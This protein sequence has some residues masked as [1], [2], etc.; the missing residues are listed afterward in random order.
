MLPEL[1]RVTPTFTVCVTLLER[2]VTHCFFAG[3][4][5]SVAPPTLRSLSSAFMTL[6]AGALFFAVMGRQG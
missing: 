5:F 2:I 4:C 6:I 3:L 1:F